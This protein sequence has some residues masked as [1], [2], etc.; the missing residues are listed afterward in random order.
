MSDFKSDKTRLS[1]NLQFSRN[2]MK[3]EGLFEKLK[4]LKE[5]YF[6]KPFN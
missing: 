5:R 1:F 4:D 6:L 3:S 2:I